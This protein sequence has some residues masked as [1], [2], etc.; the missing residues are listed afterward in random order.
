MLMYSFNNDSSKVCGCYR[1]VV[2]KKKLKDFRVVGETLSCPFCGSNLDDAPIENAKSA[3]DALF[4]DTSKHTSEAISS[5]YVKSDHQSDNLKSDISSLSSPV[6]D[7]NSLVFL[8]SDKEAHFCRDC[9][10]FMY[11]P[12]KSYCCKHEKS[13][14][15]KDENKFPFNKEDVERYYQIYQEIQNKE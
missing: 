11:H 7:G 9:E 2:S 14:W 4:T 6:K 5:L 1:S 13:H 8:D 12:Y 15:V 3:L 10:F